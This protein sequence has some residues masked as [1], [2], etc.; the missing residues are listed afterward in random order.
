M[1]DDSD[2]LCCSRRRSV[3]DLLVYTGDYRDGSKVRQ[4]ACGLRGLLGKRMCNEMIPRID[5]HVTLDHR[6]SSTS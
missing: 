1:Y 5:R 6:I 3:G 4:R 2:W